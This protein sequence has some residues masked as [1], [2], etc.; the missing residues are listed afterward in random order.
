MELLTE[1]ARGLQINLCAVNELVYHSYHQCSSPGKYLYGLFAVVVV[2]ALSRG[3]KIKNIIIAF[4][5]QDAILFFSFF[6]A[7]FY[8]GTTTTYA[9]SINSD[10][11][12]F[13][14]HNNIEHRT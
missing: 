8:P 12:T 6:Y 10:L 9:E 7:F 14:T 11:Q 3:T 1:F 5:S 4:L 13:T 2:T